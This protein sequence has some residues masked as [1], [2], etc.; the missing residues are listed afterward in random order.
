M[1]NWIASLFKIN[2]KIYLEVENHVQ[3][4]I[5]SKVTS[6]SCQ[7]ATQYKNCT[8]NVY[9]STRPQTSFSPV[10][11]PYA[12]LHVLSSNAIHGSRFGNEP[13]GEQS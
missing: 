2:S 6:A 13:A 8:V 9:S 5:S 7:P 11:D 12:A 4:E 3:D 10:P 1:I